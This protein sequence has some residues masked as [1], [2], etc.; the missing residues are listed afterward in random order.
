MASNGRLARLTGLAA[1]VAL[2][3]PIFGVT[4]AYADRCQPEELAQVPGIIDENANP[5]CLVMD[6]IVY[7]LIGCPPPPAPTGTLMGCVN[8]RVAAFQADPAGAAA[9]LAANSQNLPQYVQ[10][11]LAAAPG[12]TQNFVLYLT[13]RD[14]F[15]FAVVGTI[16]VRPSGVPILTISGGCVTV[17]KQL[18][19][20]SNLP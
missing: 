1:A 20:C 19:I 4:P 5:V 3:I 8:A 9:A 11:A 15:V 14:D 16:E 13:T 2:S 10:N 6:Q 18:P 12:T 17:S 7:P